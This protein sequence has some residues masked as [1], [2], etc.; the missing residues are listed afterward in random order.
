M[1]RSPRIRLQML[2]SLLKTTPLKNNQVYIKLFKGSCNVGRSGKE[3][4]SEECFAI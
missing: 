4:F 3:R 2:K 1:R